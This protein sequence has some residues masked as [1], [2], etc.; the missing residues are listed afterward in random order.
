MKNNNNAVVEITKIINDILEIN[1]P[2]F[3]DKVGEIKEK[4]D[5]ISKIEKEINIL[6]KQ[7]NETKYKIIK[8]LKNPNWVNDLSDEIDIRNVEIQHCRD[9]ISSLKKEASQIFVNTDKRLAIAIDNSSKLEIKGIYKKL[10]VIEPEGWSIYRASKEIL[11]IDVYNTFKS[12]DIMGRFEESDG[13][14]LKKYME[15]VEFGDYTTK[16][17]NA[18][19]E[20]L[21]TYT[22]NSDSKEYK[23]YLDKLYPLTVQKLI[24]Q[25]YREEPSVKLGFI[26]QQMEM[27]EKVKIKDNKSKR[28][29]LEPFDEKGKFTEQQYH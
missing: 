7:K 9:E 23:D 29:G 2:K 25:L 27:K 14:E 26:K 11:N 8:Y 15:I 12:D 22:I 28:K 6:Q 18:T 16:R 4:R 1:I 10:K 20:I 24:K 3:S 5:E 21:D 17:I 19:H 13:Y